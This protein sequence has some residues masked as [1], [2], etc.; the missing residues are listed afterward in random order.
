MAVAERFA[1]ES[2][3]KSERT[4]LTRP[5]VRPEPIIKAKAMAYV[6]FQRVDVVAMDQFLLDFGL[7][8]L[9]PRDGVR[10]Y[11][12][13]GTE[14]FLVAIEQGAEDRFIGFGVTV[15]S[16]E[17]LEALA[18][19]NGLPV[20]DAPTPG[21]GR[22]VR[23]VDPHGTTVDVMHGAAP[24]DAI[25]PDHM[26][27]PTNTPLVKSRINAS[28]RPPLAPSPIFKLGHVVLGR[29]DF[30]LASQW[31]MRNLGIIPSDVQVLS[32]GSPAL[33]FFRMDRGSEPADHHSI[34][35]ICSPSEAVL[36]VSFETFDIDSVGQ[37]HQYL[38][39]RGW[40]HHWGIGRHNL[41]SQFFDYWKDPA[42]D[43]WEHYADGDVFDSSRET[44]YHELSRGTLW[45]W[46]DDLPDSMRP[47]FPLE[48]IDEIH[49]AGGFGELP[50]ETARQ[51]FTALKQPPRPWLP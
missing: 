16:E 25:M 35:I 12:G 49:A 46:G 7:F 24:L 36:H 32:D 47:A 6:M 2:A 8:A 9:E 28:I 18:R 4:K 1:C 22:R 29:P 21:G 39:A 23:L 11:R 44:G 17:D 42:G 15:D 27:K 45:T 33:G 40:N 26:S 5:I 41:G 13:S 31:Y 10:Y 3:S 30:D 43:E 38:R 48:Q 14:P 37:G 20:D 34:A 19:A 50:L 51:F